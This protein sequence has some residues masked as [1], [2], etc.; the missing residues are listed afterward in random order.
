MEILRDVAIVT[1]QWLLLVALV[2]L[3]LAVTSA[4]AAANA[5]ADFNGDGLTDLAIGVPGED[6]GSIVDA[7][8][9]R[10]LYGSGSG[11]PAAGAEQVWHL[12]SPGI[13]V[14]AQAGDLLGAAIA[15]GDFNRDGYTDLAAGMP[16]KNGSRGQILVMYGGGAGLGAAGSQIWDQ[17]PLADDPES[18][19]RFGSALVA[20]DFNGDGYDDLAI[21][22][23]GEDYPGV[24]PPEA[25]PPTPN[26]NPCV[27][28]G[29]VNVVYGGPAGLTVT[30]NELWHQDR[31][32]SY[33]GWVEPQD[34]FGA[35]LAAGD[36]NG[37]GIDDL[38]VG[39]PC[40]NTGGADVPFPNNGA[41]SVYYGSSGG[42]TGIGAQYLRQWADNV[43]DYPQANDAFGY[44]LAA[45]DFNGDG[46]ADLAIGVPGEDSGGVSDAG[47]V[48]VFYG[49]AGGLSRNELWGKHSTGVAGDPLASALWGYAV[50]AG[51]FN[52]DGYADL[53]IGAP[54]DMVS[55]VAESGT[56]SLL[57]GGLPGLGGQG[58]QLFSQDT[59]GVDEVAEQVDWFGQ[60]L[61]AADLN[62]DGAHDLVI[63]VPF[64]DSGFTV[65]AGAVH[66]LYG[67]AGAGISA[68]GSQL[69]TQDGP[70]S[71]DVSE[72]GD[73]FGGRLPPRLNNV[74]PWPEV[75]TNYITTA[76]ALV[77][78]TAEGAAD[79]VH[80]GRASATVPDR[81]ADVLPQISNFTPLGGAN[82]S[83]TTQTSA[84]YAWSDGAPLGSTAGSR[85][86]L[87]VF[88]V[89]GGF[90]FS[91]PADTAFRTLKVYVGA[92]AARGQFTA[93]LSD[94]SAPTYTTTIDRSS[95][96]TSQVITLN[97]RAAS[98]G[99]TLTVR[100]VLNHLYLANSQSWITLESAAL[101][102][103]SDNRPPVLSPIGN[104]VVLEGETLSL[105]VVATDD[106]GPAPLALSATSTLPGSPAIL[107]DSGN[108]IG[109]I[110]WTSAL[111]DAAAS[112]YAVAIT[113]TDGKGASSSTIFEISVGA[114]QPPIL[115]PVAGRTVREGQSLSLPVS[116]SDPDGPPPLILSQTNTLPGGPEILTDHGAGSGAIAWT[117]AIGDAAGSPYAVTLTATDG[118]GASSS[119][120]FTITV[121]DNLAP[122]LSPIAN[123]TVTEGQTL[124][125]A[126]S[127]T[128]GDGPAPLTLSQTNTLPG[129]PNIL[130]D[131]GNGSGT[132]AWTA[133]AGSAS[134]S[135]YSV[136]VTAT[137]GAG[138]S[139]SV[140]FS[141]TVSSNLQPP[142][143][144]TP[145]PIPGRIEAENY[146]LGGSGVAYFDSTAGNA[147]NLYRSDNVD[148][149]N[150][151]DVNGVY[152][153]GQ[154]SA[155]EW[156]EY[157]VN[158]AAA[159]TYTVTLRV[160]TAANGKQARLLMNGADI[161]GPIAIPNTGGWTTWQTISRTVNLS[162]GI[163][164][165]RLQVNTGSFNINWIGFA[166]P[167]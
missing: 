94:G 157:T 15:T 142:F 57:Y 133:T 37:D 62:G 120:T 72:A 26:C 151:S 135:P 105:P 99:Q 56:V 24:G 148:I 25:N 5:R 38:A 79:W 43:A 156:L 136:T 47:A 53:A 74:A 115:A 93:S 71:P 96:R 41:V 159:G 124:S 107:T 110:A 116:A 32:V 130:T 14:T 2:C 17:G 91:V 70:G 45:G 81:K 153:V 80:W 132:L 23:P 58:S 76:P 147:G 117:P 77:N 1:R 125:L 92:N 66:V 158:V 122:V 22:V 65:D 155:G 149:W 129:N 52:R 9:V 163:Q 165:L 121:V 85:T 59:P 137:D 102:V 33:D 101:R 119:L 118:K 113:A 12:D 11:S 34:C 90:Q 27:N 16:G 7:G 3:T 150:A 31:G 39:V 82:P 123:Q 143:G 108:G 55:G 78:L 84:S 152:M 114:N 63:G 89:G 48:A 75:P 68:A 145:W 6:V 162:A 13:P 64:E 42:L 28:A 20:G 131:H 49:A 19:D 73:Q 161:T 30:R 104:Q 111:G 40:E 87:W 8:A 10:I 35:S 54:G 103:A 109:A 141:V 126:V 4:E 88:R 138:A 167:S 134:G 67:V 164:V 144:G 128:D 21:G 50:A 36:F 127:A 86:G 98:P 140:I 69:L 100:Y 160:A 106:D 18:D 154:T 112:P 61:A 44:A 46:R 97:F 139:V 166:G 83:V 60:S 51:D 95:G 29:V 146:D